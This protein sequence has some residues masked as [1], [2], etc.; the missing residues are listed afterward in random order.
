MKILVKESLN[1]KLKIEDDIL[2]PYC[3]SK[4][5]KNFGNISPENGGTIFVAEEMMSSTEYYSDID[6]IECINGHR[7]Y[8]PKDI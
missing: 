5:L 1:E 2:C 3:Q 6:L 4:R 8:I 7:F